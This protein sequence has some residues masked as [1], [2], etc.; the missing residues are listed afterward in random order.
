MKS[1]HIVLI[2]P[3]GPSYVSWR[4][5]GSRAY[6]TGNTYSARLARIIKPG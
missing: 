6:I 4:L 5:L 3:N 2:S 1:G